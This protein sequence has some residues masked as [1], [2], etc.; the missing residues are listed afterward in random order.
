MRDGGNLNSVT[1]DQY[2]KKIVSKNRP[3]SAVP[4]KAGIINCNLGSTSVKENKEFESNM[5]FG[6]VPNFTKNTSKRP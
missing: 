4:G 1:I 2:C 6:N 3:S 5:D